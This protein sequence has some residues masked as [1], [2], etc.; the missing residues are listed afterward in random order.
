MIPGS[1]AAVTSTVRPEKRQRAQVDDAARGAAKVTRAPGATHV[2]P[3]STLGSS[4]SERDCLDLSL[5]NL[6]W[7]CDLRLTSGILPSEVHVQAAKAEQ[8]VVSAKPDH[9]YVELISLAMQASPKKALTLNEIYNYVMER[10]P[11]YR[12]VEPSWKVCDC[13]CV[14][15]CVCVRACMSVCVREGVC[16]RGCGVC[17]CCCCVSFSSPSFPPAW[18]LP[19]NHDAK[20]TTDKRTS[21]C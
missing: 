16:L 6:H 9:S 5:T 14:C 7:L 3:L 4:L 15:V 20:C 13:V 1:M 12:S 10:F 18:M 17:S 19:H 2:K 8:A 11:Y 21:S